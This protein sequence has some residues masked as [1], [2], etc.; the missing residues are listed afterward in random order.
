MNFLNKLEEGYKL[1]GIDCAQ[2]FSPAHCL[3]FG[4]S[5]GA[6]SIAL[7]YGSILLRKKY[8]PTGGAKFIVVTVNHNIRP[9]KESGND[10]AFVERF[11]Q[12]FTNVEFVLHCYESGFIEKVAQKREKGIEEAARFM[13]YSAFQKTIDQKGDFPFCLAHNQNDQIETLLIRFLQGSSGRAASGIAPKRNNFIRPLLQIPR[14]VIEDFLQENSI[15]FCTDLS[16]FDNGY[17]RNRMRNQLIPFIN[18]LYLGWQKAILSGSKK[19][20]DDGDFLFQ[21]A[22]KYFSYL[23]VKGEAV[24]IDLQSYTSLHPAIKRRLLYK[25]IEL[26]KVEDRIPYAVLEKAIYYSGEDKKISLCNIK[27]IFIYVENSTLVIT[28][29]KKQVE[30]FSLL[31]SCAEIGRAHV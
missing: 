25:G 16:N 2:Y 3:Y 11:S 21:E 15:S 26:L 24:F 14:A 18:E 7:L 6:D 28:K 12:Q 9:P 4:V 13:R 31:I 30:N 5:G 20:G 10:A 22:K 17:L 19:Q 1:V 27:N 8:Y 29:N 23:E